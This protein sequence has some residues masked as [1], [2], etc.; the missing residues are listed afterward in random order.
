[1]PI[2]WHDDT[3]EVDAY[4]HGALMV[5]KTPIFEKNAK[6]VWA[7]SHV[8]TG[9]A[10]SWWLERT[11]KEAK[12][13]LADMMDGEDWENSDLDEL[14]RIVCITYRRMYGVTWVRYRADKDYAQENL[15][16]SETKIHNCVIC[17]AKTERFALGMDNDEKYGWNC[18]CLKCFPYDE[19]IEKVEGEMSRW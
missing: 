17:E 7:I 13:L 1:M 3:V 19:S 9:L 5:H 4:V 16:K 18:Y 8:Q 2:K 14:W 12:A 10:V 15:P 6:F 11:M